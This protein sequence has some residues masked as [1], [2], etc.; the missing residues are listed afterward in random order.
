[1][2]HSTAQHRT[3]QHNT[4]QHWAHGT[5]QIA[6][7]CRQLDTA[8]KQLGKWDKGDTESGQCPDH[9]L[10]VSCCN[11]HR[12]LWRHSRGR[13]DNW[14]AHVEFDVLTVSEWGWCHSGSYMHV[15]MLEREKERPSVCETERGCVCVCV[16]VCLLCQSFLNI[17]KNIMPCWPLS[18]VRNYTASQIT[19]LKLH[20]WLTVI[21]H[22]K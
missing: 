6:A 8:Q 5:T 10:C 15:C 17:Y 19:D 16:C 3:A 2:Q 9:V 14:W 1:M 11:C 7:Q 20:G 18:W 22:E 13:R 21:M 4:T 12:L